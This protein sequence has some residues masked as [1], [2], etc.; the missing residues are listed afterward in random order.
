[1]NVVI[2]RFPNQF[3][4]F[5]KQALLLNKNI[6][7][8]KGIYLGKGGVYSGSR[9]P[10]IQGEI[11]LCKEI[12]VMIKTLPDVLDYAG[13]IEYL[14]QKINWLKEDISNEQR[15]EFQEQFD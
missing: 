11:D 13:H 8:L 7:L 15:R 2:H 6:D 3:V 12:I 4:T 1:M 14:E 5:L 10:H 9:V